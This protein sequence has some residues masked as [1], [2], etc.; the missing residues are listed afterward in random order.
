[1]EKSL[2]ILIFIKE[3]EKQLGIKAIKNF[4]P[5]QPGDMIRTASDISKLKK[6]FNYFPKTNY[7]KG[8][9]KFLKWY[10]QYYKI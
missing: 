3:L 7:K 6:S 8:I 9:S 5:P 2:N 1:M 4:L 10:K